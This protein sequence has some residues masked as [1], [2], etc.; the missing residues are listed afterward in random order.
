MSHQQ[1]SRNPFTISF[2]NWT[3]RWLIFRCH[4]Q[5]MSNFWHFSYY[6][7]ENKHDSLTN[8]SCFLIYILSS[9]WWY[10]SFLHD[11]TYKIKFYAPPIPFSFFFVLLNTHFHVK[12]DNLKPVN[13]DKNFYI[14]F[15]R[16]WYIT[17]M[18]PIS[19]QFGT[20]PMN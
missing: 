20:N 14:R 3:K 2:S 8:D 1:L 4:Q 18:F 10:I 17:W 13:I 19:Y 6:N 7:C 16:F 12:D 11:K 15:V 9:V 5:R